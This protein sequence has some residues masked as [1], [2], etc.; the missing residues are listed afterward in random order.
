[1]ARFCPKCGR[2]NVEFVD[3]FCVDCY[4]EMHSFT[5]VPG[6]I[7]I[8]R[9]SHCNRWLIDKKMVKPTFSELHGMITRK[10]RTSLKNSR[11]EID[12]PEDT[13][14]S[15]T[16]K[17]VAGKQRKLIEEK[18]NVKL[19]FKGMMCD[20][21]RRLSDR[22][23]EFQIQLRKAKDHDAVKFDRIH[24]FLTRSLENMDYHEVGNYWDKKTRNGIDYYFSFKEVAK[25]LLDDI[26]RRYNVESKDT[27]EER[28]IDKKKRIKKRLVSLIR[29]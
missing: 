29:I 20:N 11:V 8:T 13:V 6:K 12:M 15:V 27:F 10:L 28:G 19:E 14:A 16:V 3:K 1:M 26:K 5:E 17:G 24:D 7:K 25:A 22:Y 9:C 18:F 21:C 4:S 23:Y 2:E